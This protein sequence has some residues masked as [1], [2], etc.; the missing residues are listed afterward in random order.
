MQAASPAKAK[1]KRKDKPKPDA[2]E[3]GV[4]APDL[5]SGTYKIKAFELRDVSELETPKLTPRAHLDVM[6]STEGFS[7]LPEDEPTDGVRLES[8]AV[9]SSYDS[10]PAPV[11]MSTEPATEDAN[12][13]ADDFASVS[14]SVTDSNRPSGSD[15]RGGEA[16]ELSEPDISRISY[17]DT[18][19]DQ[20]RSDMMNIK[21]LSELGSSVDDI[22]STKD[23]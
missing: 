18:D 19:D 3:V 11:A 17:T 14:A 15:S 10:A 22:T 23:N 7:E 1:K 13:S 6:K 21:S 20:G 8:T 12:Y 16:G 2:G 5:T 9:T 4:A